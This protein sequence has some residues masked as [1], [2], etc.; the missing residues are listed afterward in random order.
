MSKFSILGNE[1][2]LMDFCPSTSGKGFTEM[3][4]VATCDITENISKINLFV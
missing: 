3:S 1:G 2:F 4:R